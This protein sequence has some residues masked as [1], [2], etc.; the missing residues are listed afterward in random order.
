MGHFQKTE[1]AGQQTMKQRRTL[2][3]LLA[4]KFSEAASFILSINTH[5]KTFRLKRSEKRFG[6]TLIQIVVFKIVLLFEWE[7]HGVTGP[8]DRGST[9]ESTDAR[10]LPD[11]N[12]AIPASHVPDSTGYQP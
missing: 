5:T 7:V 1:D 2:R 12:R 3:H 4:M 10:E 6:Q 11:T 9:E 8:S